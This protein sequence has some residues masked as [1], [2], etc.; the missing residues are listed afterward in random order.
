MQTNVEQSDINIA[1]YGSH[2]D[3]PRVVLAP[4]NVEDC[5]YTAIEAVN[6]ASKYNVPVIILSDQGIASRIE[7]FTEPDLKKICQDLT[8]DLTPVADYKPYDLSTANGYVK[9]VV[10]GTKILSGKYPVATGLEHD[11]LGHP[12]GSPKMHLDMAAKRRKKLQAL[13]AEIP[14]PKIYGPPEGNILLVG[15]GSTEG[16]IREAVDRCR[17]NGDSVSSINI[18]HIS[19]LPNGLDDIF[20]GFNHV[21]VVEMNDEGLYG[22]GQF[23]GV[24]RARYCDP[25]IRGINKTDGLTWKV[26]DILE[27]AKSIVNTGVTKL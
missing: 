16:P 26:R 7:A 25:K 5:F 21:I 15:W 8:P 1:C 24:L 17:A 6:I 19:P 13:A 27:R 14:K 11:E 20:S 9:R 18:R 3:A 23:A 10:P 22:Y 2:G 4:S 12:S